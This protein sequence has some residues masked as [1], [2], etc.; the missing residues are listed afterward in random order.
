MK[1]TMTGGTGVM[2]AD[3][4]D[5][6]LP[7]GICVV[8]AFICPKQDSEV[9]SEA[10][11]LCKECWAMYHNFIQVS[12]LGHAFAHGTGFCENATCFPGKC[13]A[14]ATH[15]SMHNTVISGL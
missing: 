4:A 3:D 14:N 10:E 5:I 13:R 8:G 6:F 2:S 7:A 15:N 9:Q 12:K 1:A 11:N